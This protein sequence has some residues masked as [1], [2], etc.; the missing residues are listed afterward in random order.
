METWLARLTGPTKQACHLPL[1]AGCW[2]YP[3]Y[4]AV[5][6]LQVPK[7]A[8]R[9]VGMNGPLTGPLHSIMQQEKLLSAC[10]D[11]KA[12]LQV[13]CI[14]ESALPACFSH[15]WLHGR[16]LWLRNLV[17][18]VSR[19]CPLHHV[20]PVHASQVQLTEREQQG[21]IITCRC[22]VL[23]GPAAGVSKI[24]LFRSDMAVD[25]HI[26]ST[27]TICSPWRECGIAGGLWTCLSSCTWGLPCRVVPLLSDFPSDDL[28]GVRVLNRA[29][30]K[31]PAPE[32]SGGRA[33]TT[34]PVIFALAAYNGISD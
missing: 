4:D 8:G 12:F 17:C 20:T 22:H 5:H 18:T 11:G 10:G 15:C 6:V 34:D 24:V 21:N 2:V 25:T 30:M 16:V 28:Y 33:G 29:N 27:I 19:L 13:T 32:E 31:L 3:Y 9:A 7:R 1:N 26:G 23:S 14:V